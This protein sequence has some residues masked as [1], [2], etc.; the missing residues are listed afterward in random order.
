MSTKRLVDIFPELL[1]T[2]PDGEEEVKVC[3]GCGNPHIVI[4]GTPE[5]P[6]AIIEEVYYE[7]PKD[8]FHLCQK[9][10]TKAFEDIVEPN[11][12]EP[13]LIYQRISVSEKL[14]NAVFNRDGKKCVLCDATNNLS[15]DHI[16]PFSRGGETI[17]ENLQTLCMPCNIKKGA[18][19][20]EPL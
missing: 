3:N 16:T 9:C 4:I 5:M 6:L 17:Y 11:L 19:V 14:R 13:R 18:K 12:R 8:D 7:N 1:N 15:L 10:I 20:E 2:D